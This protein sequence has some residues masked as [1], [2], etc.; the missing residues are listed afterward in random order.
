MTWGQIGSAASFIEISLSAVVSAITIL[1]SVK[2]ARYLLCRR[3]RLSA[4]F[5]TRDFPKSEDGS[6]EVQVKETEELFRLPSVTITNKGLREVHSVRV[7]DPGRYRVVGDSSVVLPEECLTVEHVPKTDMKS[8]ALLL[9]SVPPVE[10]TSLSIHVSDDK[11]RRWEVSFT[12]FGHHTGDS[13]RNVDGST[14]VPEGKAKRVKKRRGVN[15]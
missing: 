3:P 4:D 12:P 8:N 2:G 15:A 9:D 14:Y 11:G 5:R 6:Y 7:V 1:A 13:W 10:S